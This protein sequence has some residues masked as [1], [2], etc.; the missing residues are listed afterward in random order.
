VFTSVRHTFS[1]ASWIWEQ[2]HTMPWVSAAAILAGG[3]V[4]LG[5][6]VYGVWRAWGKPWIVPTIM[7]H[8]LAFMFYGVLLA[9]GWWWGSVPLITFQLGERLAGYRYSAR[10]T[11]RK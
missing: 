6:G 5:L 10:S 2:L 7:I 1:R 8:L 4:I 9:R 3:L 11:R